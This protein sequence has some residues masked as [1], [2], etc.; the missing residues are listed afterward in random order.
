MKIRRLTLLKPT[1]ASLLVLITLMGCDA[2]TGGS[3]YESMIR[4]L[5]EDKHF[6]AADT[7]VQTMLARGDITLITRIA[8]N[9][10]AIRTSTSTGMLA[11][12]L[13][14]QSVGTGADIPVRHEFRVAES[15][16]KAFL[17]DNGLYIF[18]YAKPRVIESWTL[19][20]VPKS[21]A[22]GVTDNGYDTSTICMAFVNTGGIMFVLDPENDYVLDLAATKPI[23]LIVESQNGSIEETTSID[24][25]NGEV[26]RVSVLPKMPRGN[27]TCYHQA[28]A[29]WRP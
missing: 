4:E 28:F 23:N 22:S 16:E 24:D 1:F 11:R 15:A 9:A 6:Q 8:G 2:P 14:A 17:R 7:M 21:R 27:D 29:S 26:M 3:S 25:G 18:V 20:G 10:T 19:N 5:E 12:V 13:G